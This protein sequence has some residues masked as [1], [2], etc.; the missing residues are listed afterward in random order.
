MVRGECG[1][2]F[3]ECGGEGR[4]E[5]EGLISVVVAAWSLVLGPKGRLVCSPDFIPPSPIPTLHQAHL[6][7]TP[8]TLLQRNCQGKRE[9]GVQN[10]RPNR[11]DRSSKL[12]LPL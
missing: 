8:L 6:Q 10:H 7:G 11:Y 5:E 1:K 9:G 4:E 12:Y 2:D 3:S